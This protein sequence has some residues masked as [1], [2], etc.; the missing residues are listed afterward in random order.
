MGRRSWLQRSAYVLSAALVVAAAAPTAQ[1]AQSPPQ[2]AA[3]TAAPAG[4]PRP[5]APMDP[6]RARELY[7]SKDPADHARGYNFQ[8]D[9]DAK[10]AIDAQYAKASQGVMEFTKVT[11][12][13]SVGDMNIPAYL[14]QP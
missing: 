13:S 11:Y 8:R 1:Q 7:V 10:A 5:E 3:G 9:I 4:R 14:F 6:E 12:R 2:P